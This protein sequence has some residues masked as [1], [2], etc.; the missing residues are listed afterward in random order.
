MKSGV[1]NQQQEGHV[2][3]WIMSQGLRTLRPYFLCRLWRW[4]TVFRKSWATTIAL[5]A[6][7]AR[8]DIASVRYFAAGCRNWRLAAF[9]LRDVFH[10]SF[11]APRYKKPHH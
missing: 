10:R 7:Q 9:P 2:R 5:Q 6:F 3:R 4:P 1:G 8:Q 11:Y